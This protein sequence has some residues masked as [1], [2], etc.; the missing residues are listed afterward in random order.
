MIPDPVRHVQ[1]LASQDIQPKTK[2]WV[3]YKE[4]SG[5]TAELTLCGMQ[6]HYG[7]QRIDQLD[8]WKL[9][10]RF[11]AGRPAEAGSV[12][13]PITDQDSTLRNRIQRATE[14]LAHWQLA[15]ELANGYWRAPRLCQTMEGKYSFLVATQIAAQNHT[16]AAGEY[17][18]VCSR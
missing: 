11:C 8:E 2:G 16:T 17:P 1:L 5:A 3:E 10:E 7:D 6:I 14:Y 13:F 9:I 15:G 18:P 12:E 4:G